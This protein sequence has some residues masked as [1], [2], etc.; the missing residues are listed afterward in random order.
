MLN[1][2]I[3]VS[4]KAKLLPIDNKGV[5]KQNKAV[6]NKRKGI[7]GNK[8]ITCFCSETRFFRMNFFSNVVAVAKLTTLVCQSLP[9]RIL[10]LAHKCHQRLHRIHAHRV[11]NTRTHSADHFVAFECGQT[12]RL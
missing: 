8:S 4:I 1:I 2:N 11:V 3:P 9:I 7:E 6:L 5:S 10:K 12:R